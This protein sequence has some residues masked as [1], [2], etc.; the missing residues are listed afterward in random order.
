[1]YVCMPPLKVE[2]LVKWTLIWWK[3]VQNQV[4][5]LVMGNDEF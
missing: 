1:M 2:A 4:V 3:M 5:P